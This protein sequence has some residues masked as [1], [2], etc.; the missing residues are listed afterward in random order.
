MEKCILLKK[1]QVAPK[2]VPGIDW[3][4]SHPPNPYPVDKVGGHCCECRPGINEQE[5]CVRFKIYR[6]F[7]CRCLIIAYL[8]IVS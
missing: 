2:V 6:R 5:R 8:K 4:F 7:S 3:P 1:L